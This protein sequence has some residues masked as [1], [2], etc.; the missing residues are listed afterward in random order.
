M[1]PILAF[2]SVSVLSHFQVKSI[3][4]YSHPSY[5]VLVLRAGVQPIV[6]E[7]YANVGICQ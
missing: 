2:G 6:H 5:L 1:K 3:Q 4:I 7:C